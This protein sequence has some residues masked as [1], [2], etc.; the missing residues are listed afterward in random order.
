M[1]KPYLIICKEQR[2][3]IAAL[4]HKVN[5]TVTLFFSGKIAESL[6]SKQFLNPKF[7]DYS[8][9]NFCSFQPSL[10]DLTENPEC[11]FFL[12]QAYNICSQQEIGCK[13]SL[14]YTPRNVQI[15]PG[16]FVKNYFFSI[17]LLHAHLQYVCNIPT[18]H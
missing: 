2:C 1:G 8:Y 15:K 9:L 17:K 13:Q 10:I 12:Q 18:M 6:N 7:Q 4:L 14:Q 11:R 5:S 16:K 3:R